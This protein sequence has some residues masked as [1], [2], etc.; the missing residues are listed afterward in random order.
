MMIFGFHAKSISLN[1]IVVIGSN[2]CNV[3]SFQ[4]A[5]IYLTDEL[6]EQIMQNYNLMKR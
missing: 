1:W 2:S 5:Q 6:G 3:E 4:L